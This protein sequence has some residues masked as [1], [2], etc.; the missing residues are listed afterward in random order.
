MI[1]NEIFAFEVLTQAGRD[2]IKGN[3]EIMAH[4]G[5][6]SQNVFGDSVQQVK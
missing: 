6:S 4:L 3:N 2:Y 1:T 5:A